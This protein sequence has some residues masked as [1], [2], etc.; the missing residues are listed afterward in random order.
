MGKAADK[1]DAEGKLLAR[2]AADKAG[3]A[4]VDR[5]EVKPLGRLAGSAPDKVVD[6]PAGKVAGRPAD[7]AD[8]TLRTIRSTPWHC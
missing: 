6:K 8:K 4:A 5:A 2:S 1:P 3:S 7:K